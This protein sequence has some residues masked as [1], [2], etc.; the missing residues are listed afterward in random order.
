MFPIGDPSK[1]YA[2]NLVLIDEEGVKIEAYI[3]KGYMSKFRGE[4]AEGNVY[5][6]T[7]FAVGDNGGS[8]RA[9]EHAFKIFFT[10]RTRAVPDFSDVI[11]TVGLTLKNS[12]EIKGTLGESDFLIDYIGLLAEL[13][14]ERQYEKSG[15]ITRKIE[16]E[17]IDDKGKV[18]CALFG[19]YVDIVKE[20]LANVGNNLPVVVVQLAKIKSFRGHVVIQNVMNGTKVLFNPDIPEVT[21]FRNGLALHGIECDV[22]VGEIHGGLPYVPVD[23]EFLS[24][25]PRK[26]I[27]ELYSTAEEGIFIVL[28][29]R[30]DLLDGERWY[31]TSCRCHKSLTVEGGLSYCRGCAMFVLEVIPRFIIKAEVYDGEETATFVMF[32]NDSESI[33]Q[34][35]CKDLVLGSKIDSIGEYPDAVKAIV[36]REFLFKVE[37]GCDHGVK[38][39]HSFKVKKICGDCGVIEMFKSNVAVH[40]PK[41]L[42]ADAFVSNLDSGSNDCPLSDNMADYSGELSEIGAIAVSLDDISPVECSSVLSS[43]GCVVGG[44]SSDVKPSKRMR[45]RKIKLDL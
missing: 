42:M 40:T 1:P 22:P 5:K 35:S 30:S 43:A 15:N 12:A 34:K 21:S 20:Y 24:H 29:T 19:N 45:I 32:D 3:K 41:K 38:F 16:L 2:I 31:Y 37:K 39:D 17:L 28:A 25:F 8:F 4:F 33:I 11:P 26:T 36:G 7:Y 9:C 14:S 10:S 18:R 44:D 27:Q 6:I 13:P 23:E